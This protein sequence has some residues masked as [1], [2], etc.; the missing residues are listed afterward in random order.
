LSA[1]ANNKFNDSPKFK[2]LDDN[3]LSV[4]TPTDRGCNL[5]QSRKR[6]NNG[7]KGFNRGKARKNLRKRKR[8]A[9]WTNVAHGY[10]I[11]NLVIFEV[12]IND[13]GSNW[14]NESEFPGRKWGPKQKKFRI[15]ILY[16][17]WVLWRSGGGN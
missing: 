16:Y 1:S 15:S 10:K 12:R 4:S 17:D 11:N 2:E 7:G 6:I 14:L 13:E 3:L 5:K 9:K 8:K